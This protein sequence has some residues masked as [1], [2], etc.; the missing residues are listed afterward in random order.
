MASDACVAERGTAKRKVYPTT[1]VGEIV[2]GLE[3]IEGRDAGFKCK[4]DGAPD[5]QLAN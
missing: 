1:M 2:I 5:I 3:Q 4:L